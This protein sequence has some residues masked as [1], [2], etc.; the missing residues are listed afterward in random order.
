MGAEKNSSVEQAIGSRSSRWPRQT[1]AQVEIQVGEPIPN[2]AFFCLGFLSTAYM[3][4]AMSFYHA[5]IVSSHCYCLVEGTFVCFLF[6]R[7][8]EALGV[9]FFFFFLSG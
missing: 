8:M 2:R 1:R 5:G 9:I 4:A 3:S 6:V 7:I